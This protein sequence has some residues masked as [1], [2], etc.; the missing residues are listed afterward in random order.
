[1]KC[2]GCGAGITQAMLEAGECEYCHTA[3]ERPKKHVP[4][5]PVVH[6]TK[7][8]LGPR[9]EAA[10]MGEL[11]GNAFDGVTTRLVGCFTGCFSSAISLVFTLVIGGGI[12]A[13]VGYTLYLEQ[14]RIPTSSPAPHEDHDRG[15][16]DGK[17]KRK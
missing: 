7:I 8:E 6:V 11:A 16:K 4:P 17:G 3:L 5:P 10:E 12:A 14:Q 2:P 9:I 1:V 13:Y 15:G